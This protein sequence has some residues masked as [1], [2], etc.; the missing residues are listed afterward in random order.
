M[1]PP[2]AARAL[3]SPSIS[4][5]AGLGAL[6][7][8]EEPAG[9]P[10]DLQAARAAVVEAPAVPRDGAPPGALVLAQAEAVEP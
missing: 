10:N 6:A 4:I 3:K 5:S 2:R 8:A 9:H 7:H 1:L